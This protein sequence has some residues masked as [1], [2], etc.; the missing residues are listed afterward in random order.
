MARAAYRETIDHLEQALA[1]LHRLPE[2]REK[3]ELTIDIRLDLR[4]ALNALGDHP[5]MSEHLHAAEMLA[6]TLADQHRLG[7]IATFMVIQCLATGDYDKAVRFG[8]EALAVARTLGD[9][10]I[11]VVAMT[12]LG[13][14]HTATG[15]FRDATTML[16]RNVALEGDLRYE[17]FWATGIQ[18]AFSRAQLADVLSQIGRFEEAIGYAEAAVQIAETADHPLTLHWGLF[19]LGLAQLRRGNFPRATRAL[20]RGL[21]L[22]R[23]WQIAPGNSVAAATLGAAYSLAGRADEAL[24]LVAGAVEEFRNR[25]IHARPAYILQCAGTTYLS[26]GRIDEAASHAREALAL[27]RRLGARASE[28]HVLCLAGDVALTSGAEDTEGC[29]RQAQAL[30]G[31]L[32]M[33]P[34]TAHCHLG[35]GKLY[36]RTGKHEQAREHLTTATTM[37]REMGMT[38]WL[39]KSE[40][41]MRALA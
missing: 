19:Y 2:S 37:Y 25:Q 29:Y 38:Y 26:A 41:E 15:A 14:T 9:R 5:R 34:L 39:E 12:F 27:S 28:A 17:R 3:T 33:R 13:V 30:A 6:R 10:S 20:E 24:P 8:Q 16:E 32:G 11:E 35:L 31:E 36:H 22:C 1:A 18:S 23:T 7:R 21:D 40:M 4:T